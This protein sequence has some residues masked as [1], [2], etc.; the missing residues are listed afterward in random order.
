MIVQKRMRLIVAFCA[1]MLVVCLMALG[2][3][4]HIFDWF[5]PRTAQQGDALGM[6]LIDIPDEEAASFYHVSQLGVYVLAVDE[7]S[8]TDRLGIRS[9]D[10]LVSANGSAVS[11]VDDF[12]Q[13]HAMQLPGSVFGVTFHRGTD[14]KTVSVNFV[15]EAVP[16]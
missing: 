7:F 13:A 9:G 12:A 4:L 2:V 8:Q 3:C 16:K 5:K 10:R 15:H 11:S 6:V 1:A 14:Q